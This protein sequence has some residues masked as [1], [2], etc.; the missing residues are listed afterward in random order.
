M[1]IIAPARH[2]ETATDPRDPLGRLERF[3]DPGTVLPLH[4]RDKSGV[5][6][7]VGEV[8]VEVGR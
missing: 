3:F 4:S 6:A 8:A 5:L 2:Q 1:T 7:A